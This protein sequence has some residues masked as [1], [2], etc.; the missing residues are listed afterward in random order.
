VLLAFIIVDGA[1]ILIASGIKPIIPEIILKV[2]SGMFFIT[3][4]ILVLRQVV[5]E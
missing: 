5:R 3:L 2:I 4:G 1:A